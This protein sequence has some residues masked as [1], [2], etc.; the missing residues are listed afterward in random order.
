MKKINT[1][2]RGLSTIVSTLILVMLTLAAATLVWVVAKNLINDNLSDAESCFGIFDKVNINTE[3]TCY[4][5]SSDE[6]WFSIDVKDAEVDKILVGLGNLGG[7]KSFE[8]ER[9]PTSYP[10]VRLFGGSYGAMISAPDPNSALTYIINTTGMGVGGASR[11][12]ISPI[13]GGKQCEATDTVSEI[14]DCSLLGITGGGGGTTTPSGPTYSPI[15]FT[16]FELATDGWLTQTNAF[17]SS[18]SGAWVSQCDD[19][20]CDGSAGSQFF[21]FTNGYSD[22]YTQKSFDFSAVE[23]YD[24]IKIGLLTYEQS[25]E[26]GNY[27]SISCDDGLEIWRMQDGAYPDS[28]WVFHEMEIFPANCTFDNSVLLKFDG[29]VGLGTGD[30]WSIDGINITGVKN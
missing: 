28:T 7:A 19:S 10:N 5:S 3:Y 16:G 26:D 6:L 11:I 23:P 29:G 13:V 21:Y 30:F 9:Q 2:K 17:I 27:A 14:G 1:K 15:Y 22:A 4:N 24:S 25:W 12:E 20:I 8:L 18:G